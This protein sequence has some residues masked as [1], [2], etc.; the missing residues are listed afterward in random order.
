MP[1]RWGFLGALL[2]L[3][4]MRNPYQQ[5]MFDWEIRLTSVDNNRVVR[6]LDWGVE[7]SHAWPCRN[8]CAPGQTPADPEQYLAEYNQRIV[9]NSDEF[10]SYSSPSDFRLERR[11]VKVFS[12]REIPDLKLE[13]KVKG[14]HADFLRFTSP[15][16][17]PFPENNLAN[18]RWF[19]ARGR[20]AVVLLP[21]WNSD[22]LAYTSLCRVLN[23]MG[24]AVLRLSMPYHDIRMPA[25][26]NRAD[27]AVSANVG[28]TLDAVRQGVIDIRC[29]LDW[30][31]QQGYTRLG[32]VGTSLGSCYAF[33]ACA[34]DPRLRVAAFNHASTYFADVVW[35]GQSTR[36]IRAGLEP[37]IDVE[38]LRQ[39]W[40][41]ISPMSYFTQ[42][43]RF[44]RKSL[45]VYAKYDLTFL[46]EF[47]R[48]VVAEFQ[49]HHLDHKVVVLPCGHYSTGETPYKY[50]DGWHLVSFLRTA[51]EA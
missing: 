24:I 9:S 29:C 15:V 48:E 14:T 4:D 27:Y 46:P 39:L 28:R 10:Y 26:I 31:E 47:S 1:A 34:H 36:H 51:F 43:S 37:Q 7:F 30:L 12:T 33:L 38:R 8:G 19:P 20:R 16:H 41:A 45:I 25:E 49:R 6:P 18:A 32:V 44:P 42:F 50:M 35:H 23:L 11:E 2:F 21:H 3:S 40:A 13:A 22:A 17:T 5:W